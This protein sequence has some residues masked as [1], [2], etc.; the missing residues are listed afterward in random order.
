MGERARNILVRG[1]TEDGD[2]RAGVKKKEMSKNAPKKK[3]RKGAERDPESSQTSP[4]TQ[5]EE[6]VNLI[7]AYTKRPIPITEK[8]SHWGA[9][10]ESKKTEK[11]RGCAIGPLRGRRPGRIDQKLKMLSIEKKRKSQKALARSTPS[12]SLVS[13]QN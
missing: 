11:T 3:A 7:S 13:P 2:A 6:Q 4:E 8:S 9:Q 10:L 5:G 12:S 1:L